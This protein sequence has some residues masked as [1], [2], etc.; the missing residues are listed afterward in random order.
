MEYI[1]VYWDYFGIYR[2]IQGYVSFR[3][4]GLGSRLLKE[5]YIGE[6]I[7]DYYSY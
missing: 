5:G 7:G 1:G 3:V 2:D 4:E 6:C